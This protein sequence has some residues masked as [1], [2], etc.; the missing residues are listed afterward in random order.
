MT[1]Q[2][3]I[4][5]DDTEL[6]ENIEEILTAQGFEIDLAPDA[7]AGLKLIEKQTPSLVIVDN[8]MPGMGGMAFLQQMKI[9]FPAVRIIMITA[10]AT[11]DNAVDAM[12]QGASDYLSKPFKK[13]ELIMIVKK[14]L[15]ENK[16]IK[17]ILNAGM[18]DTLSCLANSTRREIITMLYRQSR[19]RFMDITRALEIEDHT[20]VNFHIKNLKS[21]KLI[22][23]DAQKNYTL[24]ENGKKIIECMQVMSS[25]LSF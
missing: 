23:Q 19:M 7:E 6:R 17:C 16:F 20:K 18:D 10:F 21:N 4:I 14:N 8:M 13:D 11:I 3:L 1:D 2:I 22:E 25:K 5:D 24:T 9:R 15:E 12:K